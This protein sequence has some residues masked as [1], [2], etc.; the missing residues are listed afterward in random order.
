MVCL[1]NLNELGPNV[2]CLLA[3]IFEPAHLNTKSNEGLTPLMIAVIQGADPQLVRALLVLG[4][5]PSTTD[6]HRKSAVNYAEQ[7]NAS[8]LNALTYPIEQH[9][10]DFRDRFYYLNL[11]DEL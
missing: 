4:A 11:T 9:E 7:L 5:D 10:L 6:S 3:C 8:A 1:S 2:W